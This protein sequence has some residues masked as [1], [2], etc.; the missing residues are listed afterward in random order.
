MRFLKTYSLQPK[1]LSM[2]S[3]YVHRVLYQQTGAAPARKL[4]AAFEAVRFVFRTIWGTNPEPP[5]SPQ[6]HRSC[7]TLT[8]PGLPLKKTI[9]DCYVAVT[10]GQTSLSQLSSF[11]EAQRRLA[12]SEIDYVPYFFSETIL[13]QTA[14]KLLPWDDIY[15]C[16]PRAIPSSSFAAIVAGLVIAR[17][18]KV[19]MPS[20]SSVFRWFTRSGL[21]RIL[22]ELFFLS[23]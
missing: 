14:T 21:R 17:P 8:L 5:H 16:E 10:L 3:G 20:E 7:S 19:L 13:R 9:C 2:A 11:S 6:V 1:R 23:A 18:T 12:S 15:A 4:Y 22:S